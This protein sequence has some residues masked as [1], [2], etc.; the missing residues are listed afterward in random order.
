M[1]KE[2]YGFWKTPCL[3]LSRDYLIKRYG[4]FP[5]DLWVNP[6]NPT[7]DALFINVY[8]EIIYI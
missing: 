7:K 4:L 5:E 8:R 3:V 6:T 2:G 1:G